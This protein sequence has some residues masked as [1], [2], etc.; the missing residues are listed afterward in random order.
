MNCTDA[1]NLSIV[2]FLASLGIEPNK[3]VG[4]VYWYRSPLREEKTA[5]FKVDNKINRWYDHGQGKGGKLVDLGIALFQIDVG[6]FLKKLESKKSFSFHKPEAQEPAYFEIRK[7]KALENGTLLKY[8]N[9]RSIAPTLAKD[10]CHEVYY[11]IQGKHYFAIGF[12][13]DS[14]GFEIRNKY[15]KACLGVKDISTIVRSTSTEVAIF[16]GFIDFLSAIQVLPGHLSNTTVIVLNSAN[17]I[18]KALVKLMSIPH[19]HLV[20]YFDNDEPGR[21]CLKRLQMAFPATI[22]GSEHYKQFK[23]FN[24]MLVSKS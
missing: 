5:S 2:S 8:L 6:E 16:E 22:D 3:I 12:E 20:A 23:D 9:D 18:D 4:N 11:Q 7:V 24:D 13:N 15:F 10:Y 17:Q 19:Q 21:I 1:N 14:H